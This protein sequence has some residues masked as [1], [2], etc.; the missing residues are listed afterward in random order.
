M[1]VF[2][3]SHATA[4]RGLERDSGRADDPGATRDRDAVVVAADDEDAAVAE[5]GRRGE[6]ER[7]ARLAGDSRS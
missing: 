2:N 5:Q 1:L 4:R 7:D 3:R 6:G